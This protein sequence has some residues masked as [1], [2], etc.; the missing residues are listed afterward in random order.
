LA[1]NLHRPRRPPCSD[2]APSRRRTPPTLDTIAASLVALI[3]ALLPTS[4]RAWFLATS[5][6][7]NQ[8]KELI[9]LFVVLPFLVAGLVIAFVSWRSSHGPPPVRTSVILAEGQ[10]AEAEV[11]AVKPLGSFLE[12][13]PMVRFSLRV[14]PGG[15]EES[16]ELEV[17]QS[18]PRGA[19]REI[20]TGDVVEVR[21]T[22]DH[23]AGAIVWGWPPANTSSY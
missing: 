10:P 2:R 4:G 3:A 17:V 1:R 18:L 21:L 6:S 16:F 14:R 8:E 22:A 9:F 19:F 15:G 5:I 13:R 23:T 7:S 11:L 12:V 20:H